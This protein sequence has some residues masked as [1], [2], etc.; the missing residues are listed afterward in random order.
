MAFKLTLETCR[1]RISEK[2]DTSDERGGWRDS[3][4]SRVLLSYG[5]LLRGLWG[6]DASHGVLRSRYLAAR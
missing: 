4:I 5:G 6:G 3:I 1:S 2:R